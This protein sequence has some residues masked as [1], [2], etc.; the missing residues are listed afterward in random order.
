MKTLWLE[1]R[2]ICDPFFGTDFK[3]L[4]FSCLFHEVE[5]Y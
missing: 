5:I 3:T 4:E 1:N 2:I